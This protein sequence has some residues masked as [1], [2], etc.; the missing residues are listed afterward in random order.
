M[1]EVGVANNDTTDLFV[2]SKPGMTGMFQESIILHYELL[3]IL[4]RGFNFLPLYL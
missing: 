3:D 2:L 1:T 4:N